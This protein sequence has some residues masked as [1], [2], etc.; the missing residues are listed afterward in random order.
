MGEMRLSTGYLR[1]L[2]Q[3]ANNELDRRYFAAV[4]AEIE[5][6]RAENQ[7]WRSLD[8][9][10]LNEVRRLRNA[11]DDKDNHDHFD[12]TAEREVL[13]LENQRLQALIDAY[14]AME[15]DAEEALLAAATKG[16]DRA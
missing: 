13:R 3:E 7:S 2:Q 15:P 11:L 6:L 10:R 14:A 16:A 1:R 12:C 4:A 8:T 9:M 5:R